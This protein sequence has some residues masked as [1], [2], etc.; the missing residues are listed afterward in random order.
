MKVIYFII[1]IIL[2]T[3]CYEGKTTDI[4]DDADFHDVAK[5]DLNVN[6]IDNNEEEKKI[7]DSLSAMPEEDAPA[8]TDSESN[9]I[10]ETIVKLEDDIYVMLPMIRDNRIMFMETVFRINDNVWHSSSNSNIVENVSDEEV[11]SRLAGN[12]IYFYNTLGLIRYDVIQGVNQVRYGSL[13]YKMIQCFPEN[14]SLDLGLY[15]V[16]TSQ[17]NSVSYDVRL[18][19]S[20]DIDID[21]EG[22]IAPM[23]VNVTTEEINEGRNILW[24]IRVETNE[25]TAFEREISLPIIFKDSFEMFFIDINDDGVCEMLLHTENHGYNL[26]GY[27]Y[28]NGKF[29]M[30]SNFSIGD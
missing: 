23:T 2:L 11:T 16:L 28:N 26:T 29:I 24:K 25:A 22:D 7:D 20:Q 17:V 6:I 5:D 18:K 14:D 21:F 3:G 30:S 27:E 12:P 13:E 15:I 1:I 10:D 8:S 19:D 9:E 4:N